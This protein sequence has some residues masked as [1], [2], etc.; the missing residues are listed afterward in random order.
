MTMKIISP[1]EFALWLNKSRRGD[2]ISY[3]LGFLCHDRSFER[4][5][6]ATGIKV[7][8]VNKELDLIARAVWEAYE[9]RK[10]IPVQ[11]KVTNGVYEY[12]AVRT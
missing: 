3:Y 1:L 10:V 6:G 8:V 4:E 9:N 2:K 11:T 5:I 7:Q 12:V